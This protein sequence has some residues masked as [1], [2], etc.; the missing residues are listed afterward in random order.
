MKP[1]VS[2]L[3]P[4]EADVVI[5]P[6]ASMPNVR[7]AADVLRLVLALAVVL[8][9]LLVATL[10]DDG[11]RSTERG[12]LNTIV[13]LP[14]SLRDSLTTAAQLVA[15]LMPVAIV[16][17]MA[18]R[19]RF[20]TVGKV[21]G[22]GAAALL[23][24]MLFSHL[25]LESSHPPTW[26]ELLAGRNGIVA[27]TI[28]P[29]VWLAATTAVLAVAGPDLSQR[30]RQVLWWLTGIVAVVEVI[31]GG[32]LPVDAVIA[33]ALGVSVGA[34]ILLIFGEPARRPTAAQVVATLRECGV[35]VAALRQ[36]PRAG[37][38]PDMFHATTREGTG[39]AVRVYAN[40]DRDRDRLARLTHWLL[41]R[42]PQD[43]RAGITVESA[44]EHELLAMVVAGRAGGRVPDPVVAYPIAG[45]QGTQGALVAWID[46]GGQPFNAVPP[47][48]IGSAT[49]ADLWHSVA[50]LHQHRLAHRRLRT[51]NITVDS[52]GQAWLTGLVL[53]ELGANDRQLASDVAE[54]LASL[55]VRIGVDRTVTA[56]VAGLGAPAVTAATA[57]L[58]PLALSDSTRTAVRYYDHQRS[59]TLTRELDRRRLRPGGRPSVY[60]D[61]RTAVGQAT[62]EPPAKPE[63]LARLTWK[64]GLTLLGAFA[65]I[66]LLV[67]QLANA[68]DAVRALQHAHWWWVLAAV[69]ALFV[70]QGFST[71]LQLGTIPAHLPFGP[72][73]V[74][75]FGGSFLNR[76]TPNNVGGMALSFRYQQQAGVDSGAA[77]ASVGLETVIGVAANLLLLAVFF[78]RTGRHTSVHFSFHIHQWV[79]VLI[80]VALVACALFGLTPRGRRFYHDKIWTFIRSAGI[81]I[82]EVAKSPRHLTLTGVGAL[83]G[84]I[85]QIVALWLCVHALGGEL[86]FAQV[87]AIYL[88]GHIVAS[89]APVP[90]GLGA[91]EAA[92]IAGLS[93][94]GMPVGAAA[95]AV[96]IYRLL[97]YWLTIPVG[98]LSLKIAED[99]GYV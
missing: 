78:T 6:L 41:V 91:L 45:G 9:G 21:I 14:P 54:L 82:A 12:L 97:T 88:G 16:L 69:P 40:D 76:V 68:G 29:V 30:W 13:T 87:G 8:V 11:V 38:S 42:D 49:L 80:T 33:A 3:P 64:K 70:A 19:R 90:G 36:L 48:E 60:A 24:G 71:L 57:Y 77:S 43:D 26:H 39:L 10:A 27:V 58:Q 32:F 73:Y 34:S 47:E 99:R 23:I 75:G 1:E 62:G 83:G 79:L 5:E 35:D 37:A 31:I 4:A 63:Q 93:A 44:G 28:P 72:T 95:S 53:A 50:R 98:W 86:P 55:A 46:V 66:Y 59:V 2:A 65:V 20:A 61:L 94:L 52:S 81:A 89:A 84:P 51:D 7:R 85:V 18:L 67:P 92:L 56:A 17:V 22:A 15:M 74:V 96:L 25:W